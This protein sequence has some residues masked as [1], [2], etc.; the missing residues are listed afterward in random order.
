MYGSLL[1]HSSH[2]HHRI[3]QKLASRA[4]VLL[5]AELDAPKVA[6]VQAL[7]ILSTFEAASN[8]ETRGWLYSGEFLHLITSLVWDY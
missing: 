8:R 2:E 7:V 6:T 3:A 1:Y 4:K 5:E